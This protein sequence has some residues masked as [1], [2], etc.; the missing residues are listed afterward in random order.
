MKLTTDS[1]E[2]WDKTFEVSQGDV[3]L[4]L[5]EGKDI[6]YLQFAEDIEMER[7]ADRSVI[8]RKKKVKE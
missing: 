1:A 8:I 4:T 5:T 2:L 7:L 6:I 3:Q